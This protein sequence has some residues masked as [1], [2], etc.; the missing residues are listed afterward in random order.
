MSEAKFTNGP[1]SVKRT[2]VSEFRV[3]VEDRKGKPGKII[4]DARNIEDANLI[5]AS[6]KMYEMLERLAGE[7]KDDM[8]PEY[9][10][11]IGLLAEARG[12]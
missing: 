7:L 6:P 5:A 11:I 8:T 12:K 3:T 1:W 2:I 9:Y 4:A 10:E